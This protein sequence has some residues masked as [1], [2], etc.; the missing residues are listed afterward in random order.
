MYHIL[1]CGQEVFYVLEKKISV[2]VGF[3]PSETGKKQ[4]QGDVEVKEN[5]VLEKLQF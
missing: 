3:N 1:S 2:P 5:Q 4:C